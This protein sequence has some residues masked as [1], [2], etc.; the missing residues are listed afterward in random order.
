MAGNLSSP[1]SSGG[2]GTNFEYDVAAILLSRLLRGA[3][4]PVGLH[5]PVAKVAFQQSNEGFPLD[6]VV[7]W[8]PEDSSRNAPFIQIQVKRHIQVITSDRE[9]IKVIGAVVAACGGQSEQ[10]RSRRLLFGLAARRSRTDHLDELAELTASARAHME[11][12]KFGDLFREHITEKPLRDRLDGVRST[13]ANA[14]G[15]SDAAVVDPLTHRILLA[16]H[17]WLVDEG[18]DSRDWREEI[19][20]LKILAAEAGK[21]PDYI[22]AKLLLIARQ[23][24]PRSGNVDADHVRDTLALSGIHLPA[25]ATGI[26]QPASGTIINSYD[27][28]T[29]FHSDRHMHF[30]SFHFGG[31]TS[32]P[33]DGRKTP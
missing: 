17:V 21:P 30:G 3:D 29:V 25:D 4:I 8:G 19:D 2:A 22:M 33:D 1:A 32:T 31:G 23:L 5:V 28:S 13:V 20:G 10:I 7:A 14:I 26:R 18:P 15:T 24:G 6:D 27:N 12:G 16:L 11:N 9:F